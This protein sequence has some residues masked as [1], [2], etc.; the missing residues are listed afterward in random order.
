MSEELKN[1]P[2]CKAKANVYSY[3]PD[4]WS[5]EYGVKCVECEIEVRGFD[6]N[7][8]AIEEWNNLPRLDE[9]DEYISQ[10][11]NALI[12]MCET[13][14]VQHKA[15]YKAFDLETVEEIRDCMIG[16]IPMIQGMQQHVMIAHAGRLPH[17]N[18]KVYEGIKKLADR[19]LE[20]WKDQKAKGEK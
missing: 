16:T 12:F 6:W 8:E 11:E 18:S 15:R 10:L 2:I 9:K 7:S 19:Y 1:C 5:T 4:Y 3:R 14:E 20:E 17:D 13:H